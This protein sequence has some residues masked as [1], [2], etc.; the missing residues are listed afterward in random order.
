MNETIS[1]LDAQYV[2]NGERL[3]A[4]RS[5][6]HATASWEVALR[7]T[8]PSNFPLRVAAAR[9]AVERLEAELARLPAQSP[10]NDRP[11]NGLLELR[12]NPRILRSAVAA[13]TPQPQDRDDLPRVV[14]G[15]R[16]EPRI[17]ALAATYLDTMSG[18]VVAATLALFVKEVQSFDP[19]TLMEIWNIPAQLSF[20]LLETVLITAERALST[21]DSQADSELSTLFASMR[22]TANTEW[23]SILESLILFDATLRQDPSGTY[24]RMDFET[25][26]GYR[27]RVAMIARHSDLTE[28]QVAAQA[29]ELAREGASGTYNDPRKQQRSSHVGYFLMNGGFAKLA[30]SVNFHPP[31]SHRLREFIRRNADDFYITSIELITIVFIAAALFPLLPNYPVFGSLAITFL[32]MIMPAMQ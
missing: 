31:V 3:D 28:S 11:I 13:V 9:S 22:T 4:L 20:A 26:Q 30:A 21:N 7:P 29:I 25:R 27:S 32:L 8:S 16:E 10:A 18:E 19:L 1:I 2:M 12:S 5:A 15:N 6:A 14:V 23:A 24:P 17:T